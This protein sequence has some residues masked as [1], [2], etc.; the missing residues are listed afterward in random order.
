MIL[1]HTVRNDFSMTHYRCV[2]FSLSEPVSFLSFKQNR[3][4][5]SSLTLFSLVLQQ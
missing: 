2:V 3:N 1:E 4:H 5:Y